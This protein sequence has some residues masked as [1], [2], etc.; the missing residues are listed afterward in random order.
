MIWVPVAG[1]G[2]TDGFR[3]RDTLSALDTPEVLQASALALTATENLADNPD[4]DLGQWAG[5]GPALSVYAMW[6]VYALEAHAVITHA[7]AVKRLKHL[8]DLQRVIHYGRSAGW[9]APPWW[10]STIHIQHQQ[11]LTSKDPVRYPPAAFTGVTPRNAPGARIL[12]CIA[13]R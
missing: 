5:H 10:G 8:A 9:L 13:A 11:A 1:A 6:A 4:S 7:E 12:S 3:Y 2:S